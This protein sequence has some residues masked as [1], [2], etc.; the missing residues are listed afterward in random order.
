MRRLARSALAHAQRQG[1]L[2]TAITV[3]ALLATGA[4]CRRGLNEPATIEPPFAL[5]STIQVADPAV[6]VQLVKGFHAVE[7]GGAWRW[8]MGRFAVNL[9]PPPYSATKGAQLVMKFSIPEII[10]KTNK[11]VTINA[12]VNGE[13][14]TPVAFTSVGEHTLRLNVPASVLAGDAVRCEFVLDKTLPP[15]PQEQRELGVIVTSIGLQK[16]P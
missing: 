14:L 4:S 11:D 10:I 8:S 15:S 9:Q 2:T 5:A 12:T 1:T 13:R 16:R 3:A 7:G 6:A